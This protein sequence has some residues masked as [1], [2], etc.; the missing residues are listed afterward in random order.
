[1]KAEQIM[2]RNKNSPQK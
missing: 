2:S 1:M